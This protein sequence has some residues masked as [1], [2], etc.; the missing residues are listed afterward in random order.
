MFYFFVYVIK[1]HLGHTNHKTT[2]FLICNMKVKKE[3][4]KGIMQKLPH[5]VSLLQQ[6]S[7]SNNY[8]I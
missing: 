5:L 3:L 7:L 1:G 6:L 4:A 8:Q 2:E